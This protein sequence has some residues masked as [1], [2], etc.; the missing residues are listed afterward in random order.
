MAELAGVPPAVRLADRLQSRRLVMPSSPRVAVA[1]PR[2]G[3]RAAIA[4]WLRAA[5]VEPVLLV[6]A[7]FVTTEFTGQPP[8][9]VVA[10]AALLTP[11]FLGAMRRGDPNRPIVAVGD[12][13][14]ANEAALARRGITVYRRPL[15]EAALHLAVSLAQAESRTARR[16][17]RK[18]VQRLA[19]SIEGVPAVL[20]D[21]SN[22]GMRIE[23]DAARG[24]R[25]SPQFVVQVP[26]LRAGV[27][28]QRVWVRAGGPG[29][30]GGARTV[31]CGASLLAT[32]DRTRAAWE[33]LADPASG[34]VMAPRPVA[35]KV[36]QDGL[37]GRVS[38]MFSNAPVVGALAQLPWRGRS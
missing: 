3:E 5:G 20:L 36:Q 17:P 32:D 8:V 27:P 23:V 9:L 6:D 24:A 34:P 11:S 2:T 13:D 19:T 25:L 14:E 30:A 29:G 31:Q 7:C 15:T 12:T 4:D 10:D 16:S 21:V 37:F 22:E 26:A 28:V 38:T 35:A 18:S 1:C 33:R